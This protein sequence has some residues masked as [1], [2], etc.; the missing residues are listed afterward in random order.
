MK[1]FDDIEREYEGPALHAEPTFHF[2]NRSAQPRIG[3]IRQVLEG[4]FS[5]YPI[6]EQAYLGTNF[7][8]TENYNH[9]AAFFELFLHEL[10]VRLNYHV[11]V[12]PRS[13][14]KTPDFLVEGPD[15]EGFYVEACLATDES[16]DETKAQA[17]MNDVY[18]ALNRLDSPN[19]F[20]GMHLEGAPATPLPTREL[21]LF[22]QQKLTEV[23]PDEAMEA[24]NS[25]GLDALPQWPYAYEGWKIRFFPLPKSPKLRGVSGVRP[26]SMWIPSS[27]QMALPSAAVKGAVIKK[28]SRYGKLDRP[29]IVAVNALGMFV[30]RLDIEQA[31]F[32][33]EQLVATRMPDGSIRTTLVRARD[34]VWMGV[35]GPTHT[36]VGAVLSAEALWPWTAHKTRLC[37]FR[38]PSAEKS[39][40]QPIVRLS[41]A[42]LQ[43]GVLDY[44]YGESLTSILDLPSNWLED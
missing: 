44:E 37:V 24:L 17:R 19:F 14:V 16:R 28:A 6:A 11:S 32:G 25:G 27:A 15:G 38:N 26:L 30:D 22:L 35:D 12:I 10:F 20:L 13:N 39:L 29:Y 3:R 33:S 34:G 4:W 2:L 36:R 41:Q 7:R 23:D 42:V 40:T 21:R 8:S 18:D 43:N 1:L 31:L 5:R 9:R